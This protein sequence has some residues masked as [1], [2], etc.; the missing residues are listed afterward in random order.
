[1]RRLFLTLL[2]VAICLGFPGSA[3]AD[4][5]LDWNGVLLGAIRV[6]KTPP[7]KASRAMAVVNVAIFDAVNGILGGATPYHV[8]DHP[9]AGASAEA[10][11]VAAAHR[12]LAALYPAQ[13]AT[14]DAA[15]Q[16]SL[17]ALP[18]GASKTDGIAWGQEVADAILDLRADDHSG[19]TVAWESPVGGGWW[20]PT[21]PAFA[22]PL[23]PNWP[24][25]TPWAM[26][27]GSQFRPPAPPSPNS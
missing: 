5:V 25:V 20:V 11:A 3:R 24:T 19:A 9:P 8:T 12:A 10:A 4:A 23:L 15:Y 2:A 14:F 22:P 17:A 21:A 7:P 13:Q 16:T 6:D 26:T 18:D 1:M 27:S